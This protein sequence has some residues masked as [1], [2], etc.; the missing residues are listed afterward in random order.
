MN[1]FH[2]HSIYSLL[3]IV[4]FIWNWEN[5]FSNEN[6]EKIH[7]F[8]I[9]IKIM[10]ELKTFPSIKQ[11]I[12]IQRNE[13]TTKKN[14]FR[15]V[16]ESE[17]FVCNYCWST[18]NETRTKI[19]TLQTS[20]CCC[21]SKAKHT[22]SKS[23]FQRIA[24]IANINSRKEKKN[25]EISNIIC[26]SIKAKNKNGTAFI[27]HT[28]TRNFRLFHTLEY[29]ITHLYSNINIQVWERAKLISWK[30]EYIFLLSSFSFYWKQA[31]KMCQICFV[32]IAI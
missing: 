14:R 3:F 31:F 20:K 16:N 24:Y 32:Y 9:K 13:T 22:F 8:S 25:T 5:L 2:S 10:Y 21:C 6:H 17:M 30:N 1:Q 11:T 23:R 26:V 18:R 15:C 28:Q 7:H 19:I 29:T 4:N 27:H 12:K